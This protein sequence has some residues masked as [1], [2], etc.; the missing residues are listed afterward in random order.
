M[1][2]EHQ[3]PPHKLMSEYQIGQDV[4]YCRRFQPPQPAVIVSI[5]RGVVPPSYAI[6]LGDHV[7]DTEADRLF[8]RNPGE[9]APS[10]GA[11]FGTP[12]LSHLVKKEEEPEEDFGGYEEAAP[13]PPFTQVASMSAQSPHQHE[14]E[15]DFGDFTE[16][17]GH[18]Q[19]NP[20]IAQDRYRPVH[21]SQH[22]AGGRQFPA[23][24]SAY[25]M[26]AKHPPLNHHVQVCTPEFVSVR[27]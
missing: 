10:Q 21:S 18:P 27:R 1:V 11:M 26:C 9:A 12:A 16:A 24:L 25:L 19:Q 20:K 15:E 13:Q 6:R 7:R 5:D 3:A 23:G 17:A 8:P 2:S 4:W 22:Q 14:E